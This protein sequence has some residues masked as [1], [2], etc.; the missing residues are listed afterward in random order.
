MNSAPQDWTR[1]PAGRLIVMLGAL[2]II[3][4]SRTQ[5]GRGEERQ[6]RQGHTDY[7][8][9]GV[10]VIIS[11]KKWDKAKRL[12]QSLST[13]LDESLWVDHKDLEKTRGYLIYV[14]RTYPPMTP[15]FKGLH[16]TIDAWHP[17][18]DEEGW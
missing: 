3:W 12:L 18:R 9:E 2:A 17:E 6:G 8:E 15:F 4:G 11:Q 14:S 7:P 5:L 10:R 13:K 1:R 16:L